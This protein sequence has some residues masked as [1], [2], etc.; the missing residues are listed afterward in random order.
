MEQTEGLHQVLVWLSRL[1]EL[2]STL[3]NLLN[4]LSTALARILASR[5]GY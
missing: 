2:L 4:M 5:S 3:A 1:S